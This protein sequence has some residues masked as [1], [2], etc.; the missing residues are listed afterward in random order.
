MRKLEMCSCICTLRL[1]LLNCH[2][3]ETSEANLDPTY[4]LKT[5]SC[6]AQPRLHLLS[7]PKKASVNSADISWD[8]PVI[9]QIPERSLDNI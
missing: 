4:S 7:R 8:A 9:P 5:T 3:H 2:Y 6:K 1:A